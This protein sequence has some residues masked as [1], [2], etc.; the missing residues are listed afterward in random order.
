MPL[1]GEPEGDVHQVLCVVQSGGTAEL[2]DP[3]GPA[4]GTSEF[5]VG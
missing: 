2:P 4:L 1:H 5:P 3:F